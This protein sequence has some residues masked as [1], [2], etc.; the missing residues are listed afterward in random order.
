MQIL[1][2]L[3]KLEVEPQ[4]FNIFFSFLFFFINYNETLKTWW[5]FNAPLSR[6]KNIP[7]RKILF[8]KNT[9]FSWK[10][11]FSNPETNYS[12]LHKWKKKKKRKEPRS[13]ILPTSF[14][15]YPLAQKY[16]GYI[17]NEIR[18][19]PSPSSSSNLEFHQRHRRLPAIFNQ[20]T[21]MIHGFY[22]NSL[23]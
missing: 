15:I 13:N 20:S 4:S 14:P 8:E 17:S 23:E 12:L 9:R 18:F 10:K 7:I 22:T 2:P 5:N 16:Q 6:Y 1:F 11:K 19:A 21:R 3:K